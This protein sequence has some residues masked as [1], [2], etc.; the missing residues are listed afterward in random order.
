MSDDQPKAPQGSFSRR[1][2]LVGSTVA[3][4]GVAA[5]VAASAT[6]PA[7]GATSDNRTIP[8]LGPHQAGIATPAQDRLVFAAFDVTSSSA[9]DLEALLSTW[10]RAAERM[11]RGDPVA[12]PL[13]PYEPPSDTGEAVG[14][15]PA[16]LT[17]T[18]GFGSSL[19]DGRFGLTA[20]RPSALEALPSFPGDD[21]DQARSGGDLCVQAC[22]DDAQVAFHAV[23]NLARLA[24]GIAALRWVQ[25]GFGR[26]SSTTSGQATPRNLLGFKDGTN[27]PLADDPGVFDRVVWVG[28]ETDQAWMRGGSYLV[29]RRIRTRLETWAATPLVA[30]QQVIGRFKSSGAPLTG[31]HEHDRVDLAARGA[32]GAHVIPDG[33]H[34][35]QA[36]PS[37]NAGVRILRRGYSFADGLDPRSGEL[38][39]GLF[40]I[41]FQR[42]PRAQFVAIQSNLA[43]NDS[44]REYLVH[45]SSAVFACPPGVDESG[46]WGGTLFRD[47]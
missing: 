35:R 15:G 18:V 28:D 47:A 33:A 30:Q 27:N 3:A 25:T 32:L 38:D 31:T 13:S 14:I 45:T 44:L 5:A 39:A 42:D 17:L 23:H 11:T 41:C 6:A 36:A 22:A 2:L 34:V 19:F 43:I 8:F 40:F 9:Q 16:G 29:A 12:P 21:L 1:R 20:R 26:T 46:V 24:T 7:A 10:S 37:T 4:A